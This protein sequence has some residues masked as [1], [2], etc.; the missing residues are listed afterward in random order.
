MQNKTVL[1]RIMALGIFL[2]AGLALLAQQ[3]SFVEQSLVLN[4]EVPVR[5]FKDG[6]FQADLITKDFELFEDG[7]PQ[8]IEA[9]YLVQ[10]GQI[11]RSDEKKRF[12]PEIERTLFLFLQVT[13]YSVRYKDALE[14]FIETN[15]LPSDNLYIVTPLKT[16][17]LRDNALGMV[18]KEDI[19]KQL[20]EILR[21]D[22]LLATS[23]YRQTIKSLSSLAAQLTAVLSGGAERAPTDGFEVADGYDDA[24]IM[25]DLLLQYSSELIRLE[26]LREIHQLKL[27][28][29]ARFLKNRPG[30]KHV[31]F[32]YQ[33][34][35]I[36]T[37]EPRIMTQYLEFNQ[38][39][40]D[41]LHSFS[42]LFNFNYRDTN[43]NIDEVEKAYADSSISIQFLFVTMPAQQEFGIRME[44]H[45]EDVY[46]AWK[47]ISAATGGYFGA[48]A[49]PEILLQTAVEATENYYLIY[50]TPKNIDYSEDRKFRRI[51]VQV[52]DRSGYKVSHRIGYYED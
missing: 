29:F 30:Q 39:H 8:K 35:F 4:V 33:R 44:E 2:A 1:I 10:D 40:H 28:D 32:I 43:F 5:V 13:E 31:F 18:T 11:K 42:D 3:Q 16:Y 24:R 48:S 27:L 47:Q 14:N 23:E 12:M 46:S 9:V 20:I 22:T 25:Q 34:E 38:E 51:T 21:S 17:R 41:V 36:P 52:K 6:K 19:Q 45:S 7:V 15:L 50:Y 37:I 49:R 26:T